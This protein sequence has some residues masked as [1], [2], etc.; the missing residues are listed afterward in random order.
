MSRDNNLDELLLK[1]KK[2][3]VNFL[4]GQIISYDAYNLL[5]YN[6]YTNLWYKV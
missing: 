5:L 2:I 1:C 4:L 6:S 3:W